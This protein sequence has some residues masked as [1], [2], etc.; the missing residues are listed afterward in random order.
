MN[1]EAVK[2]LLDSQE[3]AFRSALDV[4]VEQLKSRI[5]AAENA[6]SEVIRSL[7]FS[8]AD[9][10]ELKD[11]VNVLQK[12]EAEKEAAIESLQTKVSE[13]E[14]RLNYQEDYSRRN[15]LR[16]TGFTE[17]DETSWEQTA[18]CVSKL[19]ETK[20][21]LPSMK[22]ERAHRVGLNKLIQPRPVVVRF[23]KYS[24]REAVLRNAKK[25]KGMGIYVNEDLCPA[26][27]EEKR[28]HIPRMRKAREEG[29]IAF[30][31]HTKL[32]VKEKTVQHPSTKEPAAGATLRH[33][34]ESEVR[35]V[36]A[37]GTP[38]LSGAAAPPPRLTL[39]VA[40]GM[41]AGGGATGGLASLP[42]D[43]TRR[44]SLVT[45]GDVDASYGAITRS[46]K[47]PRKQKK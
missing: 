18:G 13:L 28:R 33:G 43:N 2:V 15:N 29:K 38:A 6:T 26:S 41:E 19:L 46:Q 27:L 10:R 5:Q 20:L 35:G 22:I 12:S 7:E 44:T 23:A 3:R 45:D 36:E 40:S 16:I 8:Q 42:L 17:Q 4:V 39:G 31:R 21:Q 11:K 32:I 14:R 9:I 30:F 25:L 37:S 47:A 1:L 34:S 24:D